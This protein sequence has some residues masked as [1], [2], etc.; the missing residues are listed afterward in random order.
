MKNILPQT[1]TLIDAS[2]AVFLSVWLISM[3]SVADD[4]V[5][6][7]PVV[8]KVLEEKQQ[9]ALVQ[10]QFAALLANITEQLSTGSG[11]LL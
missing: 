3:P 11:C 8:D 1:R 6:K 5:I 7:T 4:Q 2:I 9:K 10:D